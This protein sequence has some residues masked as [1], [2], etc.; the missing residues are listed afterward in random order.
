MAKEQLVGKVPYNDESSGVDNIMFEAM[1][2]YKPHDAPFGSMTEKWQ[3]TLDH[4]EFLLP[5][6]YNA[7]NISTLKRRFGKIEKVI[8]SPA[9][10]SRM[11]LVLLF[12]IRK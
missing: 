8:N 10:T 11:I 12:D 3:Q 5:V 4:I 7:F 6:K 9:L 1:E 2:I